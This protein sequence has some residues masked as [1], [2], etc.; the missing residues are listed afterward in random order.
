[1]TLNGLDPTMFL[2][3]Q[4]EYEV[5]I[6]Q[7]ENVTENQENND[8]LQHKQN[9]HDADEVLTSPLSPPA[10]KKRCASPIIIVSKASSLKSK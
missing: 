2:P 4:E 10:K 9:E 7:W 3:E 5:D 6:L 8:I 1:M